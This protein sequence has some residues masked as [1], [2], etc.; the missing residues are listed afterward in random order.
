[1]HFILIIF[2]LLQFSHVKIFRICMYM[3][4]DFVR[5]DFVQQ[6]FQSFNCNFTI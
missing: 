4:Y 2:N 6:L 3:Y 1:M 5:I